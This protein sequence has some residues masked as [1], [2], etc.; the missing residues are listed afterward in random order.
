VAGS[1]I[2]LTPTMT[3]NMSENMV[4]SV[5][6]ECKT[7]DAD[8]NGYGRG[9]GV[10]AIFIKDLDQAVR[11]GDPIRAVIRSTTTNS[12]GKT[13]KLAVPSAQAQSILIRK[14]YQ[15]A[16]ISDPTRTGLFECHGT[17]TAAGDV[18]EAEAI[19]RTFG[20]RGVIIGAVSLMSHS[21]ILKY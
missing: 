5:E 4:L 11:D 6:G 1:N 18:A 2:I 12:N 16:G 14:A 8:A 7:F 13:S 10:S 3:T 21:F 20:A 17:G 15:R 19:A 9:E